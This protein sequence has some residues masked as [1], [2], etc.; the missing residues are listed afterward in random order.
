MHANGASSTKALCAR[1]LL[2]AN[3]FRHWVLVWFRCI[4]ALNA[5]VPTSIVPFSASSRSARRASR[6]K[7]RL[8]TDA[9]STHMVVHVIKSVDVL[10]LDPTCHRHPRAVINLA[11][12]HRNA[13]THQ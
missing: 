10:A 11:K 4:G 2:F 8:S 13:A 1:V 7:R 5:L 12:I 6:N 3:A 9:L